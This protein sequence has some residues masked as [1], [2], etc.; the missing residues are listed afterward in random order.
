MGFK[1]KQRRKNKN[2]SIE[3]SITLQECKM[4]HDDWLNYH[5]EG[6]KAYCKAGYHFFEVKCANKQCNKAFVSDKNINGK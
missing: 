5:P 2:A 6:N 1:T 4:P 3:E